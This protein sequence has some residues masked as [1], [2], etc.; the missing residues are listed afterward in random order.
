MRTPEDPHRDAAEAT[1]DVWRVPGRST[2]AIVDLDAIAGNLT[3]FR[4]RV[5]ASTRLMAVVKANAYGHG[6]QMV[7]RAALDGG[8][9]D[10]AV[11]TVD[12]GLQLRRA[13][14][15]APILV[16][17][18]IDVSEVDQAVEGELAI[19]VADRD[20]VRALA[21]SAADAA[22]GPAPVHLKIDTGMRRFGAMAADA[23]ELA[24][25]IS[26]LPA[27]RLAGT[28]SHFAS[29]D[30][31]DETFTLDQ[32][33]VFE[34][35]IA[36]IRSA[37]IDPGLLHVANSAA[38]LRSRRYDLDVV[39]LGIS[40]YGIAPSADIPLWPGMRPALTV[41]T[42][43]R[44]VILLDPGDRVS[45]GGTYR[46]D[47]EETA[48][49]VPIGY[50]DGYHR[51]LSGRA[52]M[53]VGDGTARVRG[54]VCMDQTVIGWPSPA[55]VDLGSEVV[56]VGDGSGTAPTFS[57]L[58]ELAGTIPYE[59]ATALAPRVPRLYLKGGRV[60]A[61]EDLFGLRHVASHANTNDEA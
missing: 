38:T 21:S 32:L 11:A 28:F 41:R 35:A 57:Q 56:V 8:A 44:R 20:S 33:A 26:S 2:R 10:L 51:L 50:A 52:W 13:G 22:R 49:L 18:P 3:T 55:A 45:Y 46:A 34:T 6:A 47:R 29:A 60:V 27:L 48:A 12:E 5:T 42:L 1:S 15:R 43:I 4:E 19:A 9:S 25:L 59:L 17:G 14:I 36:A 40:L 58:A 23:A 61:V 31:T 37:G 53:G 7:A 54:R 24:S 39:R 16:L 30:E